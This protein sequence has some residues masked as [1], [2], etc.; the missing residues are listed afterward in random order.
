[1]SQDVFRL[2]TP[3]PLRQDRRHG[4]AGRALIASAGLKVLVL[5]QSRGVW[6][7][8]RYL[9]GLAPLMR[10][11]GVELVLASPSSLGLKEAWCAAGLEAVDLEL[12]VDRSIRTDGR[13]TLAGT[14]H[15]G[16]TSL[17]AARSI[18]AA[19][20]AGHFD[21]IWANA[22]WTHAE[23]SVAGRICRRPVV[24]HLHEKAMPGLGRWLRGG[25]VALATRTVAVCRA[26]ADDL[27]RPA[28]KRVCVIPNGVDTEEF[29]PASARQ[30]PAMQRTRRDLGVGAD[31]VMVLAATRVDPVKRIEDLIQAIRVIDDPRMKLVVAGATSEHPGYETAMRALATESPLGRVSLCGPRDDMT[32][33][34]RASD[35]VLHAGAVEGMPLTLIEAQA[36]GK[37]VVAY[38]VAGVGEAVIDGRTGYLVNPY[39]VQGLSHMLHRLAAD[40]GLRNEMGAQGRQHVLARHRIEDQA[41]RNV[42]LLS[43]MC[44]L[45]SESKWA[46]R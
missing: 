35:I 27:P 16:R 43:E 40:P 15:E 18:A 19:A 11:R 39:R 23:A 7:A 14:L 36:C 4:S 24:L 8:Q 6:G 29:C 3:A 31:D 13:P 17:G 22:H 21:A 32:D 25:A 38:D 42:E 41:Q 37:P 2:S 46:G 9:L 44:S 33:L 30:T 10:E 34:F 28:Q 20:R 45:A 26:I 5:D 1:M 12:P